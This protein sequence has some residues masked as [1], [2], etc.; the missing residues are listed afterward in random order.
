M[1][2]GNA[3]GAWSPD[4]LRF[5]CT[6]CGACCIGAGAVRVSDDARRLRRGEVSLRETRAK[7]CV[8][9]ESERGCVVYAARPRQCR[10]WPFWRAVVHSPERWREE[11]QNCP[12]MNRGPL[13]AAEAIESMAAA[14]G[15]SGRLPE[16]R[17]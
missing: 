6:R 12:G 16:K 3:P 14:D 5:A 7:A 11:A 4:G 13:H 2:E 9:Y 1:S 15:S 17:S 10:T 8:F